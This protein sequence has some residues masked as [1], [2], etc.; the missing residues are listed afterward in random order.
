MKNSLSSKNGKNHTIFEPYFHMM[1]GIYQTGILVTYNII[2]SVRSQWFQA[3][4]SSFLC[5]AVTIAKKRAR[6]IL[7]LSQ[8]G[9][10]EE[11]KPVWTAALQWFLAMASC[12]LLLLQS[13]I[14][15]ILL[16]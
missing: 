13:H 10:A 1:A 9:N 7:T 4:Y 2:L 8:V 6:P 16:A 5:K 15:Q 3:S 11:T 12:Y 14:Q